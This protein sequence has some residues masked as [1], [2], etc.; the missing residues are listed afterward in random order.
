MIS[1]SI[2]TLRPLLKSGIK[3][4]GERGLVDGT[5][6]P[7]RASAYANEPTRCSPTILSTGKR[8]RSRIS[9]S[10]SEE[11]IMVAYD[12]HQTRETLDEE[13]NSRLA[14]CTVRGGRA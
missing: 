2:P 1:G 5:E 4:S 14:G 13:S 10:S 9:R 7:H 6:H 11:G 3:S 12:L 8:K